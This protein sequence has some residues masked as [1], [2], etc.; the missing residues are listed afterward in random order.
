[1]WIGD[2]QELAQKDAEKELTALVPRL[3]KV[4]M[5][6]EGVPSSEVEVQVDGVRVPAEL[7]GIERYLDPG[8]REFVAIRGKSQL[9]QI[10]ELKEGEA[11]TVILRF[12][13]SK[14]LETKGAAHTS[15]QAVSSSTVVVAAV[16]TKALDEKTPAG[17]TDGV[18]R[19]QQTWGWATVGVGAA[20]LITGTVAG[21][22]V[23][24]KYNDLKDDCPGGVCAPK[25]QGRLDS[26]RSMRTLSLAGF[27]VGGV[28]A[29]LGL[30][31]LLTSPKRT[32]SVASVSSVGL[33]VTPETA[34][35]RGDF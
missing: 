4:T 3:P 16:K 11:R 17:P 26:Y 27:V 25:E 30:T 21:L 9:R 2:A 14:A 12:D 22:V 15:S 1:L 34:G 23:A 8:K 31:L 32:E 28:G 24:A 33:W 18:G 35:F 20:G 29:T 5:T 19:A 6:I 10:I 7:V 13:S